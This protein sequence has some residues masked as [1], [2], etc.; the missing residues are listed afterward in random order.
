MKIEDIELGREYLRIHTYPGQSSQHFKAIKK[1]KDRVL[2]IQTFPKEFHK[3]FG[4][5]Y[6]L[7]RIECERYIHP[8]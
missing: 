2:F 1:E 6:T 5:T 7:N 8:L 3:G 4:Q